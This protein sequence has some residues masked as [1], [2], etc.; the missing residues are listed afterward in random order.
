MEYHTNYTLSTLIK[1]VT[2]KYD[3]MTSSRS[4]E[5]LLMFLDRSQLVTTTIGVIFAH[6]FDQKWT[7]KF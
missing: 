1:N 2:K 5:L 6:N 4:N 7:G 3:N